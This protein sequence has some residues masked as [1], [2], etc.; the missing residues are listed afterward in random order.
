MKG[1][2]PGR[3]T[4]WVLASVSESIWVGKPGFT[5]E[6]WD[7]WKKNNKPGKKLGTL[8]VN[9]GGLRWRA[10]AKQ[11]EHRRTWDDLKAWFEAE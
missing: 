3:P 10:G 2:Q 8:K 11:K 5:V 4:K 7:K 1:R 9:V 6:I